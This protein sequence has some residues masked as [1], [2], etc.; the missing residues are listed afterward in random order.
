MEPLN[1]REHEEFFQ[2]VKTVVYYATRRKLNRDE[3][4]DLDF[5]VDMINLSK[6]KPLPKYV[7]DYVSL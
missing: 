1:H 5:L 6:D 4:I 2:A 7:K 3:K